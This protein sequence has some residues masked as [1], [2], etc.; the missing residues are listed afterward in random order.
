MFII[1]SSP[2]HHTVYGR[3]FVQT[4]VFIC[5]FYLRF[6]TDKSATNSVIHFFQS[7]RSYR[8]TDTRISTN[9]F[10][11][12][13]GSFQRSS[14]FFFQDLNTST[15][16]QGDYFHSSCRKIFNELSEKCIISEISSQIQVKICAAFRS[17]TFVQL[18]D[19][20]VVFK[21]SATYRKLCTH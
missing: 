7:V 11:E 19:S 6:H 15:F 12:I 13:I 18:S 10:S 16:F 2:F 8:E 9:Y 14:S 21:L 3:S 1:I 20:L 5:V 17:V 4:T